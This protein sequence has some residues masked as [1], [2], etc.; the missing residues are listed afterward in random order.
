M[1]RAR[2]I[3]STISTNLSLRLSDERID[4]IITSGIG[5]I[6]VSLDG[7]S[8]ATHQHYR[9]KSDFDLICANMRRL[10]AAR[11]RLGRSTPLLSWQFIVFRFNEHEI[12]RILDVDLV[13]HRD[14]EGVKRVG[15]YANTAKAAELGEQKGHRIEADQPRR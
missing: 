2:G 10:A 9:R 8:A 3:V 13:I 6:S 4:R 7:A 12:E 15:E 5:E 1:A 11:K 14:D